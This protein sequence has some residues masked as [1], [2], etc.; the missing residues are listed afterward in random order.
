MSS[1]SNLKGKPDFM[2]ISIK[3]DFKPNERKMIREF[4]IG[5]KE[6]NSLEPSDSNNI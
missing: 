5:A 3:E 4:E 6:A 2:G 1:L